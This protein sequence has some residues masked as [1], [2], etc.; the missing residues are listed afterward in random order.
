[1][2]KPAN[3]RMKKFM[4]KQKQEEMF[5]EQLPLE[6]LQWWLFVTEFDQR[7]ES[8]LSQEEIEK[9][10]VFNEGMDKLRRKMNIVNNALPRLSAKSGVNPFK[11]SPAQMQPKTSEAVKTGPNFLEILAQVKNEVSAEQESEK[12]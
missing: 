5:Q 7:T 11:D 1:V 8:H 4:S 3:E 10:R 6:V 2:P 12:V 9:V